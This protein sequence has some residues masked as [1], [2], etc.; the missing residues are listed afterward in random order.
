M[1]GATDIDFTK[2]NYNV[3][4]SNRVVNFLSRLGMDGYILASKYIPK[5]CVIA[6]SIGFSI[7][8]FILGMIFVDKSVLGKLP[9]ECQDFILAH[10][11]THIIKNHSIMKLVVRYT[12][13]MSLS[14]YNEIMNKSIK[15]N[16]VVGLIFFTF[17]T[18]CFLDDTVGR[19]QYC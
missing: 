12:F 8:K 9:R 1:G 19:C 15:N 4:Y 14:M 2:R 11:L 3:D 17:I 6:Y 10:E 18:I 5:N 13:Q 7:G 16:D